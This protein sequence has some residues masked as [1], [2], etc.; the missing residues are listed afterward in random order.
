MPPSVS[1]PSNSSDPAQARTVPATWLDGRLSVLA[2]AGPELHVARWEQGDGM[3]HLCRRT[4]ARA[5]HDGEE[6]SC[7]ALARPHPGKC[8]V[9]SLLPGGHVGDC[10]PEPPIPVLHDF[11]AE[12]SHRPNVLRV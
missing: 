2:H 8:G 9:T 3:R 10:M 5:V 4:D 1:S 11:R 6:R 12:A 7:P